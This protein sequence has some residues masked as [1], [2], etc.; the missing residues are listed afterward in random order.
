MKF[1]SAI[2]KSLNDLLKK[3]KNIILYGEDIEDG[4]GG[5]F[6]V[7]K[8]LSTK[9]ANRVFST[10]ISEASLIGISGGMAIGG[11]LPIVEIMFGDFIL[12][13][14]DQILNHL[15]KYEKMYN[16]QIST[17]ITIRTS[18]GGRRG[19]GPTHSQ[20][21]ESIL[22]SFPGI[23]IISPTIYHDV[24]KIFKNCFNDN[25]IKIFLEYKLFYPKD[26]VLNQN[27]KKG[28]FVRKSKKYYETVYMT[29]YHENEEAQVVIISHG[30]NVLL[31]EH[32]IYELMIEHEINIKVILP[33][34]IKP[35]DFGDFEFEMSSADYIVVI[36]ESVKNFGWGSE[37]TSIL[38]ES[39]Y[40]KQKK[41]LRIGAKE[42]PIPSAMSLE[43]KVLPSHDYIKKQILQLLELY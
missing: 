12:L 17:Q 42:K 13:G 35:I 14:A 19:Y 18:V 33:S 11:L 24:E 37:I 15:S 26:L 3:N 25:G 1:N 36:E 31:I 23:K 34:L 38:A 10:P 30:G 27:I 39:D 16:N 9:Y 4:Y 41:I 32:L 43:E 40:L 7:T 6:K 5:A 28:I 29:N 20:S 21:P 2:N 8:G 22:S